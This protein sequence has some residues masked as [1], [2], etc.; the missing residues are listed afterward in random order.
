M[1]L[2]DK[3]RKSRE[4]SV[5]VGDVTFTIRRATTEEMYTYYAKD[6]SFA[7]IC[8]RHVTGWSGVKESDLLDG[9]KKEI[10]DFSKEVFDEVIGDRQDWWKEISN[11]VLEDAQNRITAK[12]ENE[13]N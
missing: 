9:G 13:K 7:E 2:P 11:K 3:I 6:L 1:S 4:S 5:I 10:V 12:A 8:R